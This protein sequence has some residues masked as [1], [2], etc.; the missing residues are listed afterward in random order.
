M[1]EPVVLQKQRE[2]LRAFARAA[3]QYTKQV[4]QAQERLDNA[5]ARIQQEKSA[6]QQEAKQEYE[7]ARDQLSTAIQ[8]ALFSTK[9]LKEKQREAREAK[10][11]AY[12][13]KLQERAK[14][15]QTRQAKDID[16]ISKVK[17]EMRLV[18]SASI[19][20]PGP[21]YRL[22]VIVLT[23]MLLLACGG[24]LAVFG[25]ESRTIGLISIAGVVIIIAIAFLISQIY[26]RPFARRRDEILVERFTHLD[27]LYRRWLE[28]IAQQAQAQEAQARQAH[29]QALAQAEQQ[30]EAAGQEFVV[31]AAEFARQADSLSPPWQDPAWQSW[32][33]ANAITR[34]IRLGALYLS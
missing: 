7:R 31:A 17:H 13:S 26:E 8:N 23:V 21:A 27:S 28:L 20:M 24:S 2:V 16:D 14:A 4:Q 10:G 1:S 30:L 9:G 6:A 15:Q 29:Q 33:P 3:A 34:V 32:Q 5:L 22:L 12:V 11:R 19:P 25:D 18:I